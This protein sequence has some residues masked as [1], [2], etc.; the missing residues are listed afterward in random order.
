MYGTCSRLFRTSLSCHSRS[1]L[2]QSVCVRRLNN[3]RTRT[4]PL[5][6]VWM[7]SARGVIAILWTLNWHLLEDAYAQRKSC[8]GHISAK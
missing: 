6:F 2:C 1:V 7:V 3:L 4:V 5:R 8:G